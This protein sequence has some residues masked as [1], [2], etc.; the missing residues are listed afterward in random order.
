MIYEGTIFRI[1]QK[2]LLKRYKSRKDLILSFVT[3]N[4]YTGR[5]RPF[6]FELKVF[7]KIKRLFALIKLNWRYLHCIFQQLNY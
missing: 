5:I 3:T 1:N 4:D 2:H 7:L 6:S